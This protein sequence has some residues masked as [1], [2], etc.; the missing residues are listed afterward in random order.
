MQHVLN[1][2]AGALRWCGAVVSPPIATQALDGQTMP[3]QL[4]CPRPVMAFA[5]GS[6]RKCAP[7]I[8]RAYLTQQLS[9][10]TQTL[11]I[12]LTWAAGTKDNAAARRAA[13]LRSMPLDLSK[14]G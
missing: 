13:Q 10:P 1:A 8:G 3:W 6:S 12:G 11:R 9:V 7:T 5:A 2:A 4:A 14:I